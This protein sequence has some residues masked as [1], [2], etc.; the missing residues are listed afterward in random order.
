MS[1]QIHQLLE[2]GFIIPS[3][4]EMASAIVCILKGPDDQ[5]GVRIA[6]DFRYVNKYSLGDAYPLLDLSKFRIDPENGSSAI[7][8]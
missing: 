5:N 7:C 6:T 3:E 4:S 8:K 1:R 2:L